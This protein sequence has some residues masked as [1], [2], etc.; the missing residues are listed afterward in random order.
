M[1]TPDEIRAAI[2]ADDWHWT[3]RLTVDC[4]IALREMDVNTAG[5]GPCELLD[6]AVRAGMPFQEIK[7]NG[8]IRCWGVTWR[9]P[10]HYEDYCVGKTPGL[11]IVG[12]VALWLAQQSTE[13][14][15]AQ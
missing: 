2:E 9:R 8:A 15:D 3:N 10:G 7:Y 4:R 1:L 11:A 5:V 12:A 13:S 14:E 6:A